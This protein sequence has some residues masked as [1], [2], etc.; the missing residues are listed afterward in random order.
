MLKL[1]L[2]RAKAGK[3]AAVMDA[4]IAACEKTKELGKN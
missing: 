2:G 4:V 1:I 3:T